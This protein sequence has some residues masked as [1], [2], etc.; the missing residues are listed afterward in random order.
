MAAPKLKITKTPKEAKLQYNCFFLLFLANKR[1]YSSLSLI[2]SGVG[3]GRA[4]LVSITTPST[5]S[6][7]LEIEPNSGVD[8]A[9]LTK[10]A[11]CKTVLRFLIVCLSNSNC[12]DCFK[13]SN[14]NSSSSV[15]LSKAEILASSSK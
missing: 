2:S 3:S 10:S 12:P 7:S 15:V 11:V 5:N 1:R 4:S 14:F 9:N 8:R 13:A 6:L